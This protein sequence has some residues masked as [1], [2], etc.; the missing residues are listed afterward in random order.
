LHK[1]LTGHNEQVG[2][3][4]VQRVAPSSIKLWLKSPGLFGSTT[5]LA[6]ALEGNSLGGINTLRTEG[7]L[8]QFKKVISLT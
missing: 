7:I 5:E 1:S 6:M 8:R 2:A 4:G 3:F